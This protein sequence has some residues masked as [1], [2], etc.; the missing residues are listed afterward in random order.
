MRWRCVSEGV[1]NDFPA[2]VSEG[3]EDSEFLCNI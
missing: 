1:N 2:V 3:Q